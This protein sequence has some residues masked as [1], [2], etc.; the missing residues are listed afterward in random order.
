MLVVAGSR[1]AD[2]VA[3]WGHRG[4]MVTRYFA[5]DAN[6]VVVVELWGR[7]RGLVVGAGLGLVVVAWRVGVIVAGW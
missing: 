6:F 7:G 3:G 2:C 1:A 4:G 5:T